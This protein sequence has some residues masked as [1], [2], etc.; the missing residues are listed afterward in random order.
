M[1]NIATWWR[2]RAVL[3]VF[4]NCNLIPISSWN[5][6]QQCTTHISI[7]IHKHIRTVTYDI[8]LGDVLCMSARFR[9]RRLKITS[10]WRACLHASRSSSVAFQA[11]CG[12]NICILSDTENPACNRFEFTNWYQSFTASAMRFSIISEIITTENARFIA[13]RLCMYTNWASKTFCVTQI[14]K[15]HII[16][17]LLFS[18]AVGVERFP[19]A[20]SVFF[21]CCIGI[22]LMIS[23]TPISF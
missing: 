22:H 16:F 1:P 5:N 15:A 11:A 23:N 21:F 8:C 10:I 13:D 18:F 7:H 3:C 9:R 14:K 12:S 6:V 2:L 4:V 20:I 17:C 19:V